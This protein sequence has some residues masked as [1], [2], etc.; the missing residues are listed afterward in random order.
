[1]EGSISA[2]VLEIALRVLTAITGHQN[3]AVA[4]V[5]F[6]RSYAPLLAHRADDDLACDVVQQA[7]SSGGTRTTR[8][9]W[10]TLPAESAR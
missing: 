5:Q 10:P 8:R 6:L 2:E 4:D 9:K 7:L 3:P 1:M